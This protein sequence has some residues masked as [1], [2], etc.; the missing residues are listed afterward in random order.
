MG[1]VTDNAEKHVLTGWLDRVLPGSMPTLRQQVAEF[2]AP[3]FGLG[4]PLASEGKLGATLGGLP[5]S[6]VMLRYL[7]GSSQIEVTTGRHPL[8]GTSMLLRRAL[9][10][11]ATTDATLPFSVSVSERLVMLAVG[12]GRSQFRV[13]EATT[14]HWVAVG[15]WKKRHLRL[16]GSPGT[17]PDGLSLIEVELP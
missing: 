1:A 14:G 10:M 3:V 16:E 15:G 6:G 13:V 8:G 17:S 4:G 9:E 7:R 5:N 2:G 12:G 11:A